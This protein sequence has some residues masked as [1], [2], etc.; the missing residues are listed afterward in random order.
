M[1]LFDGGGG[2]MI[3]R[4]W[5][6]LGFSKDTGGPDL[7]ATEQRQF[8]DNAGAYNTMYGQADQMNQQY[9]G[10]V[11]QWEQS[12]APLSDYLRQQTYDQQMANVGYQQQDAL[13]QNKFAQARRGQIGGS[14]DMGA[15]GQIAQQGVQGQAN[16][17]LAGDQASLGQQQQDATFAQNM[18]QQGYGLYDPANQYGAFAAQN[19]NTQSGTMYDWRRQSTG[20]QNQANAEQA[21]IMGG[22]L[23]GQIGGAVGMAGSAGGSYL[24]GQMTPKTGGGLPPPNPGSNSN[25]FTNP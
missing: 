24:G 5:G 11:N 3:S 22:Y 1:G 20:Q 18:R 13:R 23:G 6:A 17:W 8:G 12:R 14:A 21:G 7:Q 10:G 25:M 9:Q 16:A 2:G 19:Q 15:Q 4:A